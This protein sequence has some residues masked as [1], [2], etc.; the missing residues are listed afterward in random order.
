MLIKNGVKGTQNPTKIAENG[1]IFL[2][3]D[4][5]FQNFAK[6]ISTEVFPLKFSLPNILGFN[7]FF[8]MNLSTKDHVPY[9]VM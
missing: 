3:I 2:Q 6:S 4:G 8:N 1:L 5:F 7:V 9:T